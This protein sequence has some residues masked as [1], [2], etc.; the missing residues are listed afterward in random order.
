MTFVGKWKALLWASFLLQ[1]GILKS[2]AH[3]VSFSLPYHSKETHFGNF[4]FLCFKAEYLRWN[5][6][7]SLL[8]PLKF[9]MTSHLE[10]WLSLPC[11]ERSTRLLLPCHTFAKGVFPPDD[12]YWC[13]RAK[14]L[15]VLPLFLSS[16]Y[17]PRFPIPPMTDKAAPEPS[18]LHHST[19]PAHQ[20]SQCHNV[21]ICVEIRQCLH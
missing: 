12:S 6:V 11:P 9:P 1:E 20:S 7:S 17:I 13:F 5:L 8:Q 21:S 15:L 10:R 2:R 4:F 16:V 19:K 3:S 14:Q 18:C